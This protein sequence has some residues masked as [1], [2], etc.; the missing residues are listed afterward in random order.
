MDNPVKKYK[1]AVIATDVVIFTVDEGKLKT[2]LIKMNKEPYLDCWAIPGGLVGP[3][4]SVDAAAKRH[5]QDKTGVSNIFLEQLYT[6]GNI[7]RDPFGRVVSVAYF[8]LIPASGLKLKTTSEYGDVKWF[9]MEDVPR[10]AYDHKKMLTLAMARLQAKLS[11]TNIIY[12]LLP[13]EFV[14]SEMQSI[15]EIILNKKM[16]KR[17]FRKKILSLN[18]VKKLGRKKGDEAHR[19]AEL[20]SFTDRSLKVVEIV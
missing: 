16:D 17:N 4:E 5:L 18:L 20:Y 8:A 2:L 7:D 11:H 12:N 9:A 19:P 6:F 15:Y 1:H 13:K 10:L 14:L 3:E